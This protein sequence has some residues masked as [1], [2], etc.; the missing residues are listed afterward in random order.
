VTQLKTG[1]ENQRYAGGTM[2]T[3]LNQLQASSIVDQHYFYY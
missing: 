2:R 3:M 1:S